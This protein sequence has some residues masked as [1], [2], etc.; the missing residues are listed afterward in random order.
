MVEDSGLFSTSARESQAG[1]HSRDSEQDQDH[2]QDRDRQVKDPD[3]DQGRDQGQGADQ[4]QERDRVQ[5]HDSGKDQGRDRNPDGDEDKSRDRDKDQESSNDSGESHEVIMSENTFAVKVSML[6]RDNY[7]RWSIEVMNTLMGH[8]LWMY[9]SGEVE[10]VLQPDKPDPVTVQYKA[11]LKK[12]ME[13]QEKDSRARSI[14]MSTLDT[15]VFNHVADCQSSCEILKRI[16]ELRD[17][18]TTD[19]L[20]G[21]MTDF[22]NEKWKEDDDVTSFMSRLAVSASKVNSCKNRNVNIGNEFI[23]AKTLVSLPAKFSHFVSSW[24]MM[25][26]KDPKLDD[27]REKLLTCER[28]LVDHDAGTSRDHDQGDRDVGDAM[29]VRRKRGGKGNLPGKC[30]KC[31]QEGHWKRKCPLKQESGSIESSDKK[32]MAVGVFLSRSPSQVIVD[33]GASRQMTWE[34]ALVSRIEKA[35]ISDGHVHSFQ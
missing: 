5:G 25:G 17:P 3:Q 13:W 6:S 7:Q 14:I 1:D 33:C 27:F 11:D 16:R 24:Y 21:S 10:R 34:Q 28:G 29:H 31:K 30:H 22:L 2:S 18:H 15:I 23:M 35:I 20:M 4:D 19:V 8:G 32:A 12:Y 26:A 9:A